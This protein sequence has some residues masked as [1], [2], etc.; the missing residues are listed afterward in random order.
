[1][2]TIEKICHKNH[3]GEFNSVLIEY[4]GSFLSVSYGPPY[5][6]GKPTTFGIYGGS[7]SWPKGVRRLWIGTEL[8]KYWSFLPIVVA[9]SYEEA[10]TLALNFKNDAFASNTEFTIDGQTV[11]EIRWNESNCGI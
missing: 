1:M 9:S 2:K 8:D 7:F 10:R 5:F 4:G 6:E 3:F 11:W